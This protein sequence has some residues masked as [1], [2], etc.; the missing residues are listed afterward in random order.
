MKH[1]K[2]QIMQNV[3]NYKNSKVIDNNTVEYFQNDTRKIR[4]HFTDIVSFGNDGSVT[5]DSGGWKTVTTK[6]RMNKFGFYRANIYQEESIWYLTSNGE[7]SVFYDGITIANSGK[8]LKP[9]NTDKK[10]Q[11]TLKLIKRYC[12]KLKSLDKLP[13]PNNGDCWMCLMFDQNNKTGEKSTSKDHLESHLKEKYIHGSL[14]F[15]SLKWA[16]YNDPA[17]IFQMDIRDSIVNSVRRYFKANL[18]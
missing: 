2:K 17:L 18:A 9:K 6:D 16:G 4:L 12:D 8:I 10:A 7:T 1:T 13:Y 15:N 3:D 5:Y 11:K 14:I